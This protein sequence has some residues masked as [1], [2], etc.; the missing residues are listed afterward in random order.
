MLAVE[1]ANTDRELQE[2]QVEKC[3]LALKPPRSENESTSLCLKSFPSRCQ[4]IQTLRSS[5]RQF[6]PVWQSF[7]RWQTRSLKLGH[8]ISPR[9]LNKIFPEQETSRN[10][11]TRVMKIK[12]KMSNSCGVLEMRIMQ[13]L[14]LE[15]NISFVIEVLHIRSLS[16]NGTNG[17]HT[18][19]S[20]KK[21]AV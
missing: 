12:W 17:E 2:L 16:T 13:A 14:P 20:T 11:M 21:T 6:V 4:T 7:S 10:F 9:N 19:K 18:T 5:L 15:R 8:T 3:S 1:F